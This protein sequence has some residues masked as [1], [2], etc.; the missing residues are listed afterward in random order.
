V[1]PKRARSKKHQPFGLE[2]LYEDRDIIVVNKAAGLLSIGTGRDEGRTAHASLMDYVQKGNHKSRERVFIVHRLDRD[3]SGALVFARTEEAKSTLQKNWNEVEKIYLAM[4]EGNPDPPE[5]TISSYLVENNALRVYSTNDPALGK[6]SETEYKVVKVQGQR[7]LLELRLLTGRKN[8]IRVH[9]A[10]KG[11]PI[12][13]DSKYGN[14]IRDN[15]RLALH[16][17]K[18]SFDHP[19]NGKRLTFTAPVPESF[20]RMSGPPP[21]K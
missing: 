17:H 4:V 1:P 3:T 16:S 15:K 20:H 8:Q 19:Y 21:A 13:G 12:I 11:W 10:D 9:L 5:G 14:K 2:I 6:L 18:L 7:A